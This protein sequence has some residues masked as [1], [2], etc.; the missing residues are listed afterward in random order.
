MANA[1]V[2]SGNVFTDR[3]VWLFVLG[4]IAVTIGVLM[5]VP[6]FLMGRHMHLDRK[7]VV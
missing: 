7:S 2:Q 3:R 1:Q 6:M 4:C 5:H